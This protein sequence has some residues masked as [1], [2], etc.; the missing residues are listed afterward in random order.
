[1]AY[2]FTLLPADKTFVLAF[3]SA[4]QAIL[5]PPEHEGYFVPGDVV[6]SRWYKT[7]ATLAECVLESK[8]IKVDSLLSPP[9]VLSTKSVYA[10]KMWN[11]KLKVA[12]KGFFA[13]GEV[14]VDVSRQDHVEEKQQ[15][16]PRQRK[17][18]IG[19]I[20]GNEN[21]KPGCHS[22]Y[23]STD[24]RIQSGEFIVFDALYSLSGE[25]KIVHQLQFNGEVGAKISTE[26]LNNKAQSIGWLEPLMNF[27]NFEAS[28]SLGGDFMNSDVHIIRY[29]T[30][31]QGEVYASIGFSPRYIDTWIIDQIFHQ[32]QSSKQ[33]AEAAILSKEAAAA[34]LKTYP[35]MDTDNPDSYLLK[36]FGNSYGA[37]E[38]QDFLNKYE[39]GR[40]HLN[41][42][43]LTI[44]INSLAG[45]Y[46]SNQ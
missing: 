29:P 25:L 43:S 19:E 22:F 21:I 1:M 38:F 26:D 10:S 20:T 12:A 3:L 41:A 44:A 34:F 36:L 8:G 13:S 40:E 9:A 17:L 46:L 24:E 5:L 18:L 35:E 6:D 16:I 4:H 2:G 39:G 32:I 28:I 15:F 27:F 42:I 45:R 23:D 7:K 37:V 11:I 31:T 14:E 30:V 33:E